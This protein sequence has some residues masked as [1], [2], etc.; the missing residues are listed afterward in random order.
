MQLSKIFI[1]LAV[2]FLLSTA[3]AH[4]QVRLP[5]DTVRWTAAAYI[6]HDG[7]SVISRA[8]PLTF[9][10]STQVLWQPLDDAGVSAAR[11]QVFQPHLYVYRVTDVSGSLTGDASA[12]I[13][14]YTMTYQ[15]KSGSLQIKKSGSTYT[16]H[17]AIEREDGTIRERDYDLSAYTI[18]HQ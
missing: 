2:V 14:T 17:F 10:G 11:G 8:K 18:L 1:A 3:A 5:G 7:D 16:L 6:K 12:G 15:G 13:V 4:S 9:Y